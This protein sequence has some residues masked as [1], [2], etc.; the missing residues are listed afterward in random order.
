MKM[1]TRTV[2]FTWS[3]MAVFLL[4]LPAFGLGAVGPG[5]GSTV[6]ASIDSRDLSPPVD[7]LW[8]IDDSALMH[9]SV[10][11]LMRE[12]PAILSSAAAT[13]DVRVAMTTTNPSPTARTM[14][15]ETCEADCNNGSCAS[16]CDSVIGCL[17]ACPGTCDEFCTPSGCEGSGVCMSYC[18]PY[19]YEFDQAVIDDG[20]IDDGLGSGPYFL[21]GGGGS[22]YAED[23]LLF[24]CDGA[25]LGTDDCSSVVG[26]EP[27]FPGGQPQRLSENAGFSP[28]PG[29]AGCSTE[30]LDITSQAIASCTPGDP[31]CCERLVVAC[32]DGAAVFQSQL[33]DLLRAMGGV[34]PDSA[35]RRAHSGFEAGLRS[36]R[37]LIE[38]MMPA[39]PR[40][41]DAT[42]GPPPCP[43][44]GRLHLRLA[45]ESGPL[46]QPCD[47]RVDSPCD[48]APLITVVVSDEE[49]ALLK[50]DCRSNP[51][52]ADTYQLPSDCIWRDGDPTTVEAC[53]RSYCEGAGLIFEPQSG[54]N[55]DLAARTTGTGLT[56][57]WRDDFV[58]G[59]ASTIIDPAL[60]CDAACQTANLANIPVMMASSCTSDPCVDQFDQASCEAIQIDIGGG[61]HAYCR[62][63]PGAN[64]CFDWCT[65][66]TPWGG[67]IQAQE[68]AC[69]ADAMC[70]WDRAKVNQPYGQ[71]AI[72]ACR[73]RHTIN[74]CQACKRHMRTLE[75]VEGVVVD[76]FTGDSLIGFETVGPV[77]ALVREEGVEAWG[78]FVVNPEQDPCELGP[79][80][81]GRGDGRAYSDVAHAT[82]GRVGDICETSYVPFLD[83]LAAD[84][85]AIVIPWIFS[86]G[87]EFGDTANWSATIGN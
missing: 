61:P 39:L 12:A 70:R 40:D 57:Q 83:Q 87:F 43:F 66:H 65:Q 37:R 73:M 11:K 42:C 53:D 33:C 31:S 30:L 5:D 64:R 45:C 47:P 36:A 38:Q 85:P 1:T 28:L 14:C 7:L 15:G 32:D 56:V 26:F 68:I 16:F 2:A 74:D 21:S 17:K 80:S 54:F 76:S 71:N 23:S 78:G 72:L 27:F 69:E 41:Y 29:T 24:D 44:E 13:F 3:A 55:P 25:V 4:F 18:Y 62:W 46:C 22:F 48:L 50:D 77:Y 34:P 49:E 84:L 58:P 35:A 20:D 81:W 9:E 86:D 8:V 59:C 82:G 10:S 75:A 60:P 6:T 19:P 51:A 52:T 79:L 67:D 63:E